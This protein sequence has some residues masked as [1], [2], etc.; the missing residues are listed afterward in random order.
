MGGAVE[1]L[2]E[3]SIYND[4]GGEGE[5]EDEDGEG[6]PAGVFAAAVAV[7]EV[8]I[9][10]A[11][12]GAGDEFDVAAEFVDEVFFGG[13]VGAGAGGVL[14]DAVG[15]GAAAFADA[16][17][18]V[19]ELGGAFFAGDVVELFAGGGGGEGFGVIVHGRFLASAARCA[20]FRGKRFVGGGVWRVVF[21][22]L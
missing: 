19:E 6:G 12:G 15:G 13:L 14:A 3:N 11:A 7:D 16:D 18:F 20:Q 4:V 17:D 21:R 2:I 22:G 9:D 1:E 5:G 8:G 10:P